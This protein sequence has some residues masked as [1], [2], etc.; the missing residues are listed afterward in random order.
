MKR[1]GIIICMAL[2]TLGIQSCDNE[3]ML[4]N[5]F[6]EIEGGEW[7]NQ[8]TLKFHFDVQDLSHMYNI[9]VNLRVNKDYKYANMYLQARLDHIS[10]PPQFRQKQIM[11]AA[12]N[13]KW[14]GTGR[15]EI[16]TLQVPIQKDVKFNKD[17][18]YYFEMVQEMRDSS[19]ANVVSAGIMVEKGP[20]VF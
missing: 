19:L 2:I 5:E 10:E 12:P 20:P 13:G 6:K 16:I 7:S 4:I 9:Y 14:Y 15:G 18:R 17:G 1:A 8:D 11:L 3:E